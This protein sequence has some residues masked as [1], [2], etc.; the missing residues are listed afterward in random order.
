VG[1]AVV[2]NRLKRWV[3]EHVRRRLE[4]L[5]K[6]LDLVIVARN[7]AGLARHADVDQDLG[8]VLSRLSHMS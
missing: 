7:P 1:G 3:R 8:T 2:R 6:G 5:P 4:S